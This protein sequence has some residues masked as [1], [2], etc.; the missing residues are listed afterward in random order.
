MVKI[1]LV[2][3]ILLLLILLFLSALSLNFNFI[4]DKVKKINSDISLK[5][6]QTNSILFRFKK[7]LVHHKEFISIYN[8]LDELNHSLSKKKDFLEEINSTLQNRKKNFWNFFFYFNS[9][10]KIQKIYKTFVQDFDKFNNLSSDLN[11]KWN[12]VEEIWSKLLAIAFTCRDYLNANKILLE[13]SYKTIMDYVNVVCAELTEIENEKIKANFDNIEQKLHNLEQKVFNLLKITLRSKNLEWSLF[14]NL[15]EI[16]KKSKSD[17]LY[18]LNIQKTIA[19][20][21]HS[22]SNEIDFNLETKIIDLYILLLSYFNSKVVNSKIMKF[23]ESQLSKIKLIIHFYDEFIKF[24]EINDKEFLD[25]V[26]ILR[27]ILTE[28][29]NKK[30]RGNFENTVTYFIAN[31]T[32]TQNIVNSMLKPEVQKEIVLKKSFLQTQD[33]YY[34]L[35]IQPILRQDESL[36][37]HFEKLNIIK[38]K[39][40]IQKANINDLDEWI[41]TISFLINRFVELTTYKNMYDELFK[42]RIHLYIDQE[43]RHSNSFEKIHNIYLDKKYDLAFEKMIKFLEKRE[44]NGI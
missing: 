20:I 14:E 21:Q 31:L 19:N 11:N 44:K 15:P 4:N 42:N 10:K 6:Q 1:F 29:E 17:N 26:E 35:S 27:K 34:E 12:T 24:E 36:R 33:L 16:C 41:N 18:L 37:D 40:N 22:Y 2:F 7:A 39:F 43:T 30:T 13:N 9:Y 3:L 23:I 8:E 32:K 28:F 25:T 38:N 5:W